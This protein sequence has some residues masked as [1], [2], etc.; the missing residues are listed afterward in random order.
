ME[1]WTKEE[2]L[3]WLD[4]Y[5]VSTAEG[6]KMLQ[7][8]LVK[9]SNLRRQGKLTQIR[10]GKGNLYFYEDMTKLMELK[11]DK[12]KSLLNKHTLTRQEQEKYLYHYFIDKQEALKILGVGYGH[13]YRYIHR[14][15]IQQIKKGGAVLYF[16]EEIEK[17]AKELNEEQEK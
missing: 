5:F 10:W 17:K 9:L 16:R 14:D 4:Q 11:E 6:A 1:I 8:P 12:D 3:Q 2:Q 7:V 15:E 13:F